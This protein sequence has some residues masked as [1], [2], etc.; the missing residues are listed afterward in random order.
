[1]ALSETAVKVTA[2]VKGL[3]RLRAQLGLLKVSW[4]SAVMRAAME[5]LADRL[6]F[7]PSQHLVPVDTERLKKSGRL[8]IVGKDLGLAVQITYDTPYAIYVHENPFAHHEP[9]TQWKFV[10]TPVAENKAAFR[11]ALKGAY[12]QAY[13]RRKRR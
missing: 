8:K 2:N 10:D 1:M 6:F 3:D 9:P 13:A 12:L 11:K 7:Q 4:S 5:G